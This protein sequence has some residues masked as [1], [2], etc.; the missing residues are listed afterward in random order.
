[1]ASSEIILLGELPFATGNDRFSGLY[2][3]HWIWI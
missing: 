2:N 1:M 3:P